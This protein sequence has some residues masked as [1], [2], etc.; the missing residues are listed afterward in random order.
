MSVRLLILLS[1]LIAADGHAGDDFVPGVY[2][3]RICGPSCAH[4]A[5]LLHGTLVL[6]PA[7]I[8]DAAGKPLTVGIPEPVNGCFRFDRYHPHGM[9]GFKNG[10]Y[11]IW[12][13]TAD[14]LSL[15][16][17]PDGVDAGYSMSLS[18]AAAAGELR[19]KGT[20]WY[21]SEPNETPPPADAIIA[22]RTGPAD[23][24]LCAPPPVESL[25][26]PPEHYAPFR[27]P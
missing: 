5:T 12:S 6:L 8:R 13:G 27:S 17:S 21:A 7:P 15:N 22:R 20:T 25:R 1:L 2:D 4:G 3:L 24:A 10:G 23:P 18:A 26:D 14:G 19:G 9:I 11:L 16:F